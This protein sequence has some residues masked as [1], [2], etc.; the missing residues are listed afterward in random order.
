MSIRIK[1]ETITPQ[2]AAE[3]LKSNTENRP[4]SQHYVEKLATAINE[5][6]WF[7]NGE[8][9]KFNGEVLIDGQHRLNAVIRSG[10]SIKSYVAYGLESGT[11]D[12]IDQGKFRS[13][14]DVLARAGE[15]HYSTLASGAKWLYALKHNTTIG[16]MSRISAKRMHKYIEENPSIRDSVKLFKD[17]ISAGYTG[18]S[19]ILIALHCYVAEHNREKADTFFRGVCLGE[20]LTRNMPA[21]KLRALM[22]KEKVA[23]R[24]LSQDILIG[25]AIKAWN[26][27]INGTELKILKMQSNEK[28][29]EISR[30]E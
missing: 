7:L 8:T 3:W 5:G 30:G 4:L 28:L 25:H 24:K 26:A 6:E 17:F 10:K 19:G 2:R 1:L 14:G 27:F 11:Y 18:P 13:L 23:V 20:H 16:N 22:D 29:P 15:K 9:I 12:T 21:Y